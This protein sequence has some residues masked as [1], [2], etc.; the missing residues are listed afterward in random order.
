MSL[1]LSPLHQARVAAISIANHQQDHLQCLFSKHQNRKDLTM[2]WTSFQRVEDPFLLQA[3][4]IAWPCAKLQT[5]NELA[6]DSPWAL[7]EEC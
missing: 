6:D 3:I 7:L 4:Q 2:K 1:H 5:H